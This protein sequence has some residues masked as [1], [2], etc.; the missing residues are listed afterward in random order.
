MSDAGT[1]VSQ[2]SDE[3]VAFYGA[4]TTVFC[5]AS[6]AAHQ[7]FAKRHGGQQQGGP[8]GGSSTEINVQPF[9]AK[10]RRVVARRDL[11]KVQ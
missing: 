7:G 4:T 11:R 2:T 5:F 3:S 8:S 9:A 6:G 10:Q 1:S